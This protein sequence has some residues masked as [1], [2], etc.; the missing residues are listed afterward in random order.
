M[1]ELLIYCLTAIPITIGV[2]KGINT[3]LEELFGIHSSLCKEIVTM[4]VS[5]GAVVFYVLVVSKTLD[6]I[7]DIVGYI[8]IY[9]GASGI[10]QFTPKKKIDGG[11]T[12][13]NNTLEDEGE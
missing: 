6:I 8:V 7:M 2:T 4:I 13:I 3:K 10:Y 1:N 11:Q 5:L 12:P 9:F